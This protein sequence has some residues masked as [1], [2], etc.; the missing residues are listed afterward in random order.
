MIIGVLSRKGGVGKTTLAVHL[1]ALFARSGPTLLVDEDE[2]HNATLW[3]RA[4]TMPYKT[5]N[6]QAMKAEAPLHEHI[7]VDSRGGMDA[8][9]M[10]DLYLNADRVVVPVAAEYM[11]MGT[12]LQTAEVLRAEDPNLERLQIV[13]TMTRP[14]RKLDE[15]RAALAEMG[16]TP[17]TSTIRYSEAFKDATDQGV[18]VRDVKG[19]KLAMTC[20]LDCEAVFRE[21]TA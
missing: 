4:G 9:S 6:M 2:T 10:R 5:V 3:A 14:G 20:W 11:T 13:L 21:V 15:A 19:N 8:Q 1:A 7:V 17:V 16:L 18:L 12:L